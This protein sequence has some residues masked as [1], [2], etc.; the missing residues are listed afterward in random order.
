MH[1]PQ[2]LKKGWRLLS[3]AVLASLVV[4]AAATQAFAQLPGES[5][6]YNPEIVDYNNNNN[7]ASFG[8]PLQLQYTYS[9]AR[10]NGHLLSVWRGLT[11]LQVWMSFDNRVA[12]TVGGTL[13]IP[14]PLWA[15]GSLFRAISRI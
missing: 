4:V 6:T 1:V 14:S 10:N 11:N 8:D 9:E 3:V 15:N 12:F 2:Y 13:T 7:G 5:N